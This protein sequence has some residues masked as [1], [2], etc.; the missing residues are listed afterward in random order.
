MEQ[1]REPQNKPIYLWSSNLD[2]GGKNIL[3]RKDGL[4]GKWCWEC[5]TAHVNQRSKNTFKDYVFLNQFPWQ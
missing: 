2:K 5:W 4:W 1:N 3:W